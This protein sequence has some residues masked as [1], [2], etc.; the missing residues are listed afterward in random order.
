MA[1]PQDQDGWLLAWVGALLWPLGSTWWAWVSGGHIN[2]AVTLGLAIAG[3]TPWAQVPIYFAGQL[4]GA[5][6]GA[7]L[8]WL[9][10]LAHWEATKDA[11]LKLVVFSTGPA[12][13]NMGA[14][15][16]CEIIGTALLVF[17]VCFLFL[18]KGAT[19]LGAIG[20]P[21]L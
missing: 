8:V 2:P 1:C 18:N 21:W 20:A 12:I 4:V 5:F 7:I 17:G 15:L 19:Q 9:A 11:G 14:A 10:Y 16:L 13:R 6:A 3:A